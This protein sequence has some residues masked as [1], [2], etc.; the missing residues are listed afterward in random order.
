ME[1]LGGF[2]GNKGSA[3]S[4]DLVEIEFSFDGQVEAV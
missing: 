3:S 4:L 1:L 2:W